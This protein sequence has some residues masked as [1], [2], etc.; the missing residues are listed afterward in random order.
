MSG[1][2]LILTRVGSHYP[3]SLRLASPRCP[4]PHYSFHTSGDTM[5]S[6][7]G[8]I[9]APIY[10]WTFCAKDDQA[11]HQE[12]KMYQYYCRYYVPY[13]EVW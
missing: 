5:H 1:S 2:L 3:V 10:A 6:S 9:L 4:C 7:G 11:R 13:M 8:L 12:Q